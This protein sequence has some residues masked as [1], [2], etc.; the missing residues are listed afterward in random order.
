[1]CELSVSKVESSSPSDPTLRTGGEG[2][3]ISIIMACYNAA[4][5]LKEAV[6]S[7]LEQTNITLEVLIVDDHSRDNS[8]ELANNLAST[9]SRIR[10]LETPRNCG[11]GAARNVGIEHMR[12]RWYAMLDCDDAFD[13][14]RC[15]KLIDAAE[16]AGADMIA[17]DLSVF[18]EDFAASPHLG[19]GFQP[20]AG[21][22]S[23]DDYFSGTVM[24]SPRPNLGF[25]KPIIRRKA[26]N[27]IRYRTD[28]RIG[29]DD[30]LVIRL[31]LAGAKYA[32][33]PKA[34]YRYRKHDASISHRLSAEHSAAMVQSEED[35]RRQVERAGQTSQAYKARYA[36]ILDAAAFSHSVEALKAKNRVGA[37]AAILKRP[38]ALRHY[39]MPIAA[40]WKRI[41][42]QS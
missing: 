6:Q 15:R 30:E 42:S 40:R 38:S 5:Y 14:D 19:K 36:S 27:S 25:L 9:D 3:E 1:M 26:L 11:P 21:S 22:I 23:L 8:L 13:P 31:L 20:G 32:Y 41:T 29:E 24:F 2:P 16:A 18:G 34:L 28:L 35:I 37:I 7:A 12:G 39:T 17:D 33:Y 4:P 10:V